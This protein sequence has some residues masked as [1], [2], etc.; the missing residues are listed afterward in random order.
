MEYILFFVIVITLNII[1]VLSIDFSDYDSILQHQ[2]N[3]IELQQKQSN[4]DFIAAL[5]KPKEIEIVCKGEAEISIK[6]LVSDTASSYDG[7]CAVIKM[8]GNN[9][10][11]QFS[12]NC[13]GEVNRDQFHNNQ[14]Y[15]TETE[16]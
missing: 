7:E 11:F 9:F 14:E 16:L 10:D 4:K 3:K 13:N 12:L 1:S 2:T 6:D 5:D 15:E 8:K